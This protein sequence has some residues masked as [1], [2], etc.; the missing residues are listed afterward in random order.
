[1]RVSCSASRLMKGSRL[2]NRT[3]GKAPQAE[4]TV[5]LEP[6]YRTPR[7]GWGS[8]TFAVP[9]AASNLVAVR[10]HLCESFVNPH[11]GPP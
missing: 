8:G 11:A 3:I 6:A 7:N 1:M 9:V 5:L 4:P 10:F 2:E